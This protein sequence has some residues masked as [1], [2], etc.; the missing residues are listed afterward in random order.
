M[1]R[2]EESDEIFSSFDLMSAFRLEI[3]EGENQNQNKPK[4]K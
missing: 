1:L 2:Y 4:S 3:S